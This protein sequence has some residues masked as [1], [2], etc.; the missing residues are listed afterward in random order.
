[1]VELT[2]VGFHAAGRWALR[3]ISLR[4]P[5][6]EVCGLAGPNGA[7]KSLLLAICATVA[8][9]QMGTVRIGGEDARAHPAAV[10]RL[11]G[12]VP[13]TIGMYPRMTVREDLEFFAGAHGLSR[14]AGRRAVEETLERWGLRT[15]A[16]DRMG[17]AS[18]G[19]LQRVALG[20][21]WL[22]RPRLLL[23]DEPAAGL[24][25]ESCEVLWHEIRRHVEAGGSVL[26]ASHRMP[27]LVR[28]SHRIGFLVGGELRRVVESGSLREAAENELAA[29]EEQAGSGQQAAGSERMQGQVPTT[30]REPRAANR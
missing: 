25:A 21:A 18:R 24:D 23:L 11:I 16:A 22:H 7:G 15:A 1:V 2:Q 3:E 12:H 6:G 27:D 19:V 20:R 28:R 4:V 9:V 8:P 26:L 29:G 13:E 30:S 17:T 14:S 10:R 5:E